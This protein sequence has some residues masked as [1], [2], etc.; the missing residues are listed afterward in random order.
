MRKNR[1]I[2]KPVFVFDLDQTILDSD[3]IIQVRKPK[4][5]NYNP[6]YDMSLYE[7]YMIPLTKEILEKAVELRKRGTISAIF[8]LSNN[9]DTK[10][11][12][13][14]DAFLRDKFKQ[15]SSLAPNV[16]HLKLYGSDFF[17]DNLH[18][19]GSSTRE[20]TS[21]NPVKSILDVEK[22]LEEVGL[23]NKYN[24]ESRN[25]ENTF[26][27]HPLYD[28][29]YFFDDLPD[30]VLHSQIEKSHS[31]VISKKMNASKV[32]DLLKNS[33]RSTQTKIKSRRSH[34]STRRSAKNW[35]R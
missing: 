14:V 11:I 4:N 23:Y 20:D 7:K 22:M 29:I 8:L 6:L 31:F 17:F 16:Q 25:Q 26:L 1:G 34:R 10:Y 21:Q 2:L 19:R 32:S 3:G 13:Q 33:K 24:Y 35:I 5:P 9:S 12:L 15:V 28:K 18:W 30:H 27:K